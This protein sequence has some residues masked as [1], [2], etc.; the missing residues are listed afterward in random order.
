[1]EIEDRLTVP[2]PEGVDLEL[3]VAGLGSRFMS[4]CVDTLLQVAV[5]VPLLLAAGR[6]GGAAGPALGA[7]SVL[8]V[9]VGAPAACD[10]LGGGRTPGRR[11]T[12]LQLVRDDGSAVTVVPAAVRN[13]VRLVDFLPSLYSVGAVSVLATR[14]HQ[15][16]GD[17]AAGTLVVRTGAV[18]RRAPVAVPG[19]ARPDPVA[20]DAAPAPVGGWDLT[21]V[22]A[23]DEAVVR[24]F[25]ARR[26]TL[27][28]A[29]RAR[30]AGA[31]ARRLEPV[32]V[33][34]DRAAGDEAFLE[35]V[36]AAREAR[37]R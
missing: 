31:L 22:T 2:T 1:M 16:L 17:L 30:V 34:P 9:F 14:H 21:G 33:G 28:H 27:D 15:R 12:G 13:I 26:G 8:V 37:A 11:A 7:V 35:Q 19:A 25:L 10:A 29:A 6:L 32:V 3:V 24:S 23:A 18:R 5:L 36:L 4:S 20:D